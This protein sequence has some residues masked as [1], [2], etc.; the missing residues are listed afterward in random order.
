MALDFD[1]VQYIIDRMI[2][3]T[4]ELHTERAMR[5]DAES[6]LRTLRAE[7]ATTIDKLADARRRLDARDNDVMHAL[8]QDIAKV[9]VFTDDTEIGARLK[10]AIDATEPIPF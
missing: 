8:L 10:K 9:G 1:A 4:S 5:Q 7:H 3:A 6:V 2:D